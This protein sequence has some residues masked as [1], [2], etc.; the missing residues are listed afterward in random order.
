MVILPPT[1]APGIA[2]LR[3]APGDVA[4][5]L[6]SI[7]ELWMDIQPKYPFVH[8][9][10]EDQYAANH[11]RDIHFGSLAG[12]FTAL[13]III[14]CLGIVGLAAHTAERRTKEL[15]IR[16]ALGASVRDVVVLLCKDTV[17]WVGVACILGLPLGYLAIMW[18]LDNFAYRVEAGGLVYAIAGASALLF[19][20]LSVC[21][22]TLRAATAN[23]VD[24]LRDE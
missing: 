17:K 5:T 15:G 11:R 18:W 21:A 22:Y 9:F 13:S 20:V 19:A 1:F 7:R 24:A 14:A 12:F 16:K 23:P 4:G 2:V 10:L 8:Y 3:L 6:G